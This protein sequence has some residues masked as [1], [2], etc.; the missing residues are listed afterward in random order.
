LL[1]QY[2]GELTGKSGIP[3]SNL[4]PPFINASFFLFVILQSGYFADAVIY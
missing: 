3:F 2:Q 4:A 1:E